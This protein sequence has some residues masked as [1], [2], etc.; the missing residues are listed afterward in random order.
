[1]D[2]EKWMIA[3]PLP[4][5]DIDPSYGVIYH[6]IVEPTHLVS[7][8]LHRVGVVVIRNVVLSPVPFTRALRSGVPGSIQGSHNQVRLFPVYSIH[9]ALVYSQEDNPCQDH[10][11]ATDLSYVHALTQQE[12]SRHSR[13]SRL[14]GDNQVGNAGGQVAQANIR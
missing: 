13:E 11:A 10:Q 2:H 8:P 7:L 9:P 14:Q 12:I 4:I 6:I 1:M 5:A 3:N